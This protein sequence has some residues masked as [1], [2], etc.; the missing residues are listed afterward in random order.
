MTRHETLVKVLFWIT[1]GFIAGGLLSE[2][3][4]REPEPLRIEVEIDHSRHP[5]MR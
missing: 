4:H 5:V 3:R 1:V 2:L